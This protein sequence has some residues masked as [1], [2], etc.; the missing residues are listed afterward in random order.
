MA[1]LH[2][3]IDPNFTHT[4]IGIVR[5]KLL[6]GDTEGAEQFFADGFGIDNKKLISRII[7]GGYIMVFNPDGTGDCVPREEVSQDYINSIGELPEYWSRENLVDK[8][9]LMILKAKEEAEELVRSQGWMDFHTIHKNYDVTIPRNVSIK[10]LPEIPGMDVDTS[11]TLTTESLFDMFIRSKRDE[12]VKE[13]MDNVMESNSKAAVV[14]YICKGLEDQCKE[15]KRIEKFITYI[16]QYWEEDIEDFDKPR[17]WGKVVLDPEELLNVPKHERYWYIL[18]PYRNTMTNLLQEYQYI[19]SE[20]QQRNTYSAGFVAQQQQ[21]EQEIKSYCDFVHDRKE[22]SIS[23]VRIDDHVWDAGWISPDGKVWAANGST[24]SMIHCHL[25]DDIY[26]Y[27]GWDR[28]DNPDYALEG[29]GW[30]KFHHQELGFAGYQPINVA[31]R[32]KITNRQKD[33]LVEYAKV[34]GY[35]HF[36]TLFNGHQIPVENIYNLTDEGWQSMFEW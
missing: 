30:L 9:R 3:T 27:M 18:I 32:H 12:D 17:F 7:R 14:L 21:A 2:M 26:E 11:I 29:M 36:T 15:F 28:P 31:E 16:K 6:A 34:M 10:G 13:L 8:L 35:D 4:V 20:G 22:K 1:T 5:D 25:A 23:P 24:A 19:Y 33:R